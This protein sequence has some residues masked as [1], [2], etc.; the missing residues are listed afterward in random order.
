MRVVGIGVSTEG[1]EALAELLSH[2]SDNTGAAFLIAHHLSP[3]EEEQIVNRLTHKSL[4]PITPAKAGDKLQ[5]DHIYLLPQDQN[6]VVEGD[7]L[8]PAVSVP[9]HQRIFPIDLLFI[10]LSQHIGHLSVGLLLS[11]TSMD[12]LRGI[13]YI[14]EVGGL[15]L[16]Q[17]A[18]SALNTGLTQ[19]VVRLRLADQMATPRE[20]AHTLNHLSVAGDADSSSTLLLD[21]QREDERSYF[22][23]ILERLSSTTHNDFF[24]Y[25]EHPLLQRLANRMLL[26]RFNSLEKYC[27]F[28]LNNKPE[29]L[30]LYNDFLISVAHFHR[31]AFVLETLEKEVF[32]DIFSEAF[33]HR[34]V[35]IWVPACSTGEEVYS[36][37]IHIERYLEKH[38][39]HHDYKIFGTD[40]DHNAIR[41]ATEGIYPHSIINDLT[42]SLI[43]RFFTLDG[44]KY[45]IR[46]EYRDK[47]LFAVQN[48]LADPPFIHMDLISCR[49]TLPNFKPL[50]QQMILSTFHFALNEEGFLMLG[51]E[52][53]LG[54]MQHVF[55]KI[56][57]SAGI[58]RKSK[59]TRLPVSSRLKTRMQ[60]KRYASLDTFSNVGPRRSRSSVLPGQ[61]HDPFSQYL[62]NH[63]APTVLF[64]TAD[65]DLVYSN[66]R[67]DQLFELPQALASLKISKM[68][69]EKM[70]MIFQN[71]VNRA[72]NSD[73]AVLYRDIIFEKRGVTHNAYLRFERTQLPDIEDEVVLVEIML[74]NELP[75]QDTQQDE[76]DSTAL[77]NDHIAHLHQQIRESR[78]RA[79]MLV[80]ELEATNEEL[81]ASNRELLAANEELQSTNE[82]LQSVNEELYTVNNELQTKNE[83]LGTTNNDT[84]NLLRSTQIGTIFLDSKL[85]IRKFTP[86]VRQQFDLL[87][88]D[89]G[90][91]ITNFAGNFDK[92]DIGQ[93][94]RRVYESLE[95]FEQVV[96]DTMGVHYL[97]RILPYRTQTDVIEGLVVTF[98]NIDDLMATREQV[99]QLALHFHA[100][101]HYSTDYIWILEPDGIIRRINQTFGRYTTL[102]AK[103]VPFTDL[104]PETISPQIESAFEKVMETGQMQQHHVAIDMLR[105]QVRQFHLRLLPVS[106]EGELPG[107]IHTVMLIMKDIT[108]ERH[109]QQELEESLAEYKSFMD[110]AEDQIVLIDQHANIKYLN[111]TRHPT[112]EKQQLIGENIHRYLPEEASTLLSETVERIFQGQASGQIE[113]TNPADAADRSMVVRIILTPVI[114]DDD[115]RYASLIIRPD[116]GNGNSGGL[117]L[118]DP[119]EPS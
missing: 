38:E 6:L 88:S 89:V 93:I 72:L 22:D 75:E 52:E 35:R 23:L 34:A 24:K 28:L 84:N 102:Q 108:L 48:I 14:K 37:A 39:L 18:E 118:I 45:R 116:E 44:D 80:N 46:Q 87:N 63:F 119:N 12:G 25:Q 90:R 50:T 13:R 49:N 27:K 86:A 82:E 3:K 104:L 19:S 2:L 112:L 7:R 85:N 81:Q 32:P 77:H 58:F 20:L 74:Q 64:V 100:I 8:A 59:D 41:V 105:D 70:V 106:E 114:L 31:S 40:I 26:L 115:V 78:R 5:A 67:L 47:L 54:E 101:F 111:H 96:T 109:L 60:L 16:V 56:S 65:L 4:L 76:V 1:V 43:D 91:S 113:L 79:Q 62:I 97:L 11:G 83:A 29:V 21:L 117:P 103:G 110:N 66:G 36:L 92:L 55:D 17:S 51:E 107:S 33:M 9:E 57:P 95:S 53:Q 73:N 42:P 15:I 68:L 98:V 69:P 10:S 71:G 99:N 94:C 30:A 61:L